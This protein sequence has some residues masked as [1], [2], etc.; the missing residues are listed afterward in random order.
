MFIIMN[1]GDVV[2]LETMC[3][4]F[5]EI[6]IAVQ[7]LVSLSVCPGT[8]NGKKKPVLTNW[9]KHLKIRLYLWPK[10]KFELFDVLAD[11]LKS[12]FSKTK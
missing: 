3:Y 8:K 10:F 5:Y 9:F 1:F 7:T 6:E 12:N 11:C 2:T 4:H